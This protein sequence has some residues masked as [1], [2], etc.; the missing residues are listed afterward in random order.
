MSIAFDKVLTKSEVDR[1]LFDLQKILSDKGFNINES[2][3]VIQKK[4]NKEFG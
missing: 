1:L 4:K 2:L 3:L